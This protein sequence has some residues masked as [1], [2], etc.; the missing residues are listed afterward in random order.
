MRVVL[1][2]VLC[3][4]S[5]SGFSQ[6]FQAEINNQVWKPFISSFNNFDAN[7]FLALHSKDVVRSPLEAKTIFTWEEYLKNQQEGD[8]RSREKG[9]IR[10]LE[11]RFTERIATSALAIDIGVF[12]VTLNQSD[13]KSQSFYGRFHVVLR[14]EKGTWKILVDM[15]SSEGRTIGE[16]D[17]TSANAME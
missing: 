11:L 10:T 7:A 4:L 6:D 16:D 17:F 8:K 5:T 12:K 14:K 13:G 2:L 15:D 1:V 3:I 9:N